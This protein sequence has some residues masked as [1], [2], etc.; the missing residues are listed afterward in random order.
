MKVLRKFLILK[1]LIDIKDFWDRV[2][3]E[4]VEGGVVRVWGCKVKLGK[5][6]W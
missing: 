3:K 5:N 6:L 2:R 1:W 4:Y